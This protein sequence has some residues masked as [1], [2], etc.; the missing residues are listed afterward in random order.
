MTNEKIK[1]K[2]QKKT[3]LFITKCVYLIFIFTRSSNFLQKKK[4][5][6]QS[7]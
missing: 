1:K 4:W 2:N 5:I 6:T 7:L 3:K